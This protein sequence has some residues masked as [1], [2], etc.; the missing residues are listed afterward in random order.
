MAEAP[1]ATRFVR[2]LRRH[3]LGY[4]ALLCLLLALLLICRAIIYSDVTPQVSRL[5]VKFAFGLLLGTLAFATAENFRF[6]KA[7]PNYGRLQGRDRV[8]GVIAALT[9]FYI[10]LWLSA[11]LTAEHLSHKANL[12]ALIATTICVLVICGARD[13]RGVGLGGFVAAVFLITFGFI[14]TLVKS[15]SQAGI[16][17]L[18]GFWL[19]V[20]LV[21]LW[22]RKSARP[23]GSRSFPP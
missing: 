7:P 6:R 10:L 9:A 22:I 11:I 8:L 12:A 14:K 18:I 15:G 20:I 1:G 16:P 19:V 2:P 21:G 4:S 5:E 13:R 17:L 23:P 3:W